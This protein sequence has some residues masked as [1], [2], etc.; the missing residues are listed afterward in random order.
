VALDT[1]EP[2][3]I[4]WKDCDVSTLS[5][6]ATLEGGGGGFLMACQRGGVASAT[7]QRYTYH[8]KCASHSCW[9]CP[10]FV[11]IVDDHAACTRTVLDATGWPHVHEGEMRLSRGLPP[12]VKLDL[13]AKLLEQPRIGGRA[14][15]NYLFE[16]KGHSFNLKRRI[17]IYVNNHRNRAPAMA[18]G[19]SSYGTVVQ[20]CENV[21]NINV[22]L[23]RTDACTFTS[24]V[25][26]YRV[27]ESTERV[28]I[29][30]SSIAM[31]MVGFEQQV[32]GYGRGYV[33][34]DWTYKIFLERLAMVVFSTVSIQQVGKPIAFGPTS[35]EDA[36]AAR[37]SAKFVK[38]WVDLLIKGIGEGVLPDTW[39]H[40]VRAQTMDK[41]GMLIKAH[42]DVTEYG[43]R[44]GCADLAPQICTGVSAVLPTKEGW[45]DC[46]VHALRAM[47][48]TAPSK[49]KNKADAVMEQLEMDIKFIAQVPPEFKDLIWVCRKAPP[50]PLLTPSSPPLLLS[51]F[52]R[53]RKSVLTDRSSEPSMVQCSFFSKKSGHMRMSCWH[54]WRR[55][56]CAWPSRVRSP[57]RACR[58]TPTPSSVSTDRSRHRSRSRRMKASVCSSNT[59][60]SSASASA[61]TWSPSSRSPR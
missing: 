20:L 38:A 32:D 43:P 9:K 28:V 30:F 13:N 34:V 56:S 8:L 5:A 10:K 42:P 58:I 54:T 15:C 45:V 35:H 2:P 19:V 12:Q 3:P 37:D 6:L 53:W 26:G 14:M 61:A 16:V 36:E 55:R 11:K 46:F 44:A 25:V 47:L 1:S 31:G 60:S 40:H 51:P 27:D 50:H 59:P 49:V 7:A 4:T 52:A 39:S 57:T 17:L 33:M 29:I 21:L 41:Y 48:R 18:L 22:L 23:A 24:G